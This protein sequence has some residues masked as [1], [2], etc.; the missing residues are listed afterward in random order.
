MD[1]YFDYD[2]FF[3]VIIEIFEQD[4]EWTRDTMLWWNK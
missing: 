2:V 4:E 3:N 1:G